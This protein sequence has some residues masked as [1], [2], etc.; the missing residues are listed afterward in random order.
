MENEFEVWKN[1]KVFLVTKSQRRYSGII[2]EVTEHF[3]FLIDKFANKVTINI[4][5]ISSLEEEK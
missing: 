1:K 3:I 2:K 4:S 5:E